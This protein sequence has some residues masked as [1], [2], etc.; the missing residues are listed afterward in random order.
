M[1]EAILTDR[2]YTVFQPQVNI[3]ENEIIGIEVLSRWNHV[4]LGPISPEE[5]ISIAEES[6]QI[7][8]LTEHIID[9]ALSSYNKWKKTHGFSQ[10]EFHLMY[11]LH[12]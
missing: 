7:R 10:D 5:F 2:F 11:L 8:M 6:G 4:E 9:T 12:L 3:I 1:K